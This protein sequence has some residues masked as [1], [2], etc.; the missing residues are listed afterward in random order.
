MELAQP[1]TISVLCLQEPIQIGQRIARY[2]VEA[3]DTL[4]QWNTISTGTTIGNKKLDRV[5][6]VT[7]THLRVS[8]D[9]SLATPALAA[10]QL[11]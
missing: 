1:S 7:A 10:I 5:R 6:P 2:H 3:R 4:G 8:I 11:Y 9:D